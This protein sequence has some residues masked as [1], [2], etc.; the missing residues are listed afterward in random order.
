M[1]KAGIT[2]VKTGNRFD[3]A[4][5]GGFRKRFNTILKM[6]P[7][8]SQAVSERLTDHKDG[9]ED[10]YLKPTREELFEEYKK[11]IPELVFDEAEKLKIKLERRRELVGKPGY[12]QEVLQEGAR[13]ARIIARET[14][15]EVRDKMGISEAAL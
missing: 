15:A 6:N 12:V 11:A 8:I 10:N 13:R 1:K 14:L 7:N 3:L 2:R 4:S 9:L 5:C